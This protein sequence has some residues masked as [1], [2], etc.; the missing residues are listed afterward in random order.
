MSVLRFEIFI[1]GTTAPSGPGPPQYRRFMITLRNAT[2]SRT[3][4]YELSVRRWDLCLTTHNNHKRQTSMPPAR[5]KSKIPASDR[6]QTY[7]LEHA[8]TGTG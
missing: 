5:F 2:F 3:P 1:R 8:A 7:V 6:S 4:L